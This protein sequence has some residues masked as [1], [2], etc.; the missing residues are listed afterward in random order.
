MIDHLSKNLPIETGSDTTWERLGR[1]FLLPASTTTSKRGSYLTGIVGLLSFCLYRAQARKPYPSFHLKI[2]CLGLKGVAGGYLGLTVL[3]VG[4]SRFGHALNPDYAAAH[5]TFERFRPVYREIGRL[6]GNQLAKEQLQ[7]AMQHNQWRCCLTATQLV[8]LINQRA[9][10]LNLDIDELVLTTEIDPSQLT[11]LTYVM[12]QGNRI[13]SFDFSQSSFSSI[14][15]LNPLFTHIGNRTLHLASEANQKWLCWCAMNE[16]LDQYPESAAALIRNYRTYVES[17][18]YTNPPPHFHILKSIIGSARA[19]AYMKYS[20]HSGQTGLDIWLKAE[21]LELFLENTKNID[22]PLHSLRLLGQALTANQLVQLSQ[23]IDRFHSRLVKLDFGDVSMNEHSM[24]PLF[25]AISRCLRLTDLTIGIGWDHT[26]DKTKGWQ[27][28]FDHSSITHLSWTKMECEEAQA[29]QNL[30]LAIRK[31]TPSNRKK[32][33]NI[34]LGD[35]DLE[36]IKQ[37]TAA[38]LDEW[39]ALEITPPAHWDSTGLIPWNRTDIS[40]HINNLWNLLTSSVDF[41]EEE[42]PEIEKKNRELDNLSELLQKYVFPTKE[43][44]Q[45]SSIGFVSTIR[46]INE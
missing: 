34:Y 27:C 24:D 35:R 25:Q 26:I 6:L 39:D 16:S 2:F 12:E 11:A 9:Q 19:A 28:L 37:L 22:F 10:L 38:Y 17:F 1:L 36:F 45:R 41:N 8:T 4:L 5:L 3:G 7:F 23:V 43:I 18:N 33:L 44:S 30:V 20:E 13:T 32:I 40:F 29:I 31:A 21:E 15:D 42:N 14:E 46:P